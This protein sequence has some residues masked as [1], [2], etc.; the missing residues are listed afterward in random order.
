MIFDSTNLAE[1]NTLE[2]YMSPMK[3]KGEKKKKK[4]KKKKTNRTFSMEEAEKS[5]KKMVEPTI[6]PASKVQLSR[7]EI[8]ELT[9]SSRS[10]GG[11]SA[12]TEAPPMPSLHRASNPRVGQQ[13][14]AFSIVPGI[15]ER[16]T[17]NNEQD[18]DVRS[19][20]PHELRQ[21]RSD[22]IVYPRDTVLAP[23]A[24]ESSILVNAKLVVD[25]EDEGRDLEAP[26]SRPPLVQAE[27]MKSQTFFLRSMLDNSR[28]RFTRI[29]GT[30][31]VILIILGALG[32]IML[33]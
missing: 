2:D 12:G 26:S 20:E 14:G 16:S 25:F 7:E 6:P 24:E 28:S 5:K 27:P 21:N 8:K 9:Q 22:R 17:G 33:D 11:I 1:M 30:A 23:G 31:I 10:L 15:V 29:G 19:N 3:D 13:P 4:I 32:F 18:R